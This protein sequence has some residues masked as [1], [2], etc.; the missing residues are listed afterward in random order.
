M[1]KL[2]L[3]LCLAA[4][5]AFAATACKKKP[6]PG[7]A[8]FKLDEVF[9]LKMNNTARLENGDL[10]LTFSSVQDSRCPKGANCIQEGDIKISLIVTSGTES[11]TLD[12]TRKASQ[13][14]NVTQSFGSY[15]IQWLD[16]SPYPEVNKT[17]KQEEYKIKLAVRQGK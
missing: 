3:V 16:V 6:Q 5:F 14:G 10:N 11:K 9:D 7:Y 4:V 12:F 13:T 2:S 15:K 1:K 17:V 8:T